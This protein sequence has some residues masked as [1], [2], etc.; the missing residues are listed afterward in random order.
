MS[1]DLFLYCKKTPSKAAI[2]KVILPLGFRQKSVGKKHSW[3]FWFEEG[4]LASTRGCWLEWY[5]YQAGEEAPR[6]TKTIFV[7]TTYAGRSYEDFDMQNKVIRE[8]RNRFG[9]SVYN[10][11][12]GRYSY[13]ENDIPK[14][15]YPEKRCGF[16]YLNMQQLMW[17]LADIPCEVPAEK[18]TGPLEEHGLMSIHPDIIRNNLLLPFPVS[19]LES[20]LRDLFVAFVDSNPNLSERIY[21]RQGKLEY[22]ALR[23]LLEGKMSLAEHEANNYSFQNLE[24]ANVAFQRYIGVNL[25]NV[26][27]KRKKFSGKFYA[28]REVLQELL[29]LRHRIIHD[30]YIEPNLGRNG[31]I[32]YI[33]FVEYA[34]ALLARHLEEE[35][36]FRIDLEKYL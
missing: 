28:V 10:T 33:R 23:D 12:D 27:G 22:A 8:L 20:F 32:R 26:W 5:K 24:S 19:S 31:T 2:E 14:L 30:A 13:L 25:F 4:N 3:Y 11:D 35:K 18:R 7:A 21:Q 1:V 15:R 29:N 17:R 6:G 9:G 36:N 16:V 34:V